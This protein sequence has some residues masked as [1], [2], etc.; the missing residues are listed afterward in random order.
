[1]ENSFEPIA[2]CNQG[3]QHIKDSRQVSLDRLHKFRDIR[4]QE[5]DMYS[6]TQLLWMRADV[7]S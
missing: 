7:E 3:T 6:L 2:V 5:V 4:I 1:M